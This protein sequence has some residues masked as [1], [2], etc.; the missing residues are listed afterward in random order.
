MGASE[1]STGA[2]FGMADARI[3]NCVRAPAIQRDAWHACFAMQV[4]WG[5]F[6]ARYNSGRGAIPLMYIPLVGLFFCSFT[7]VTSSGR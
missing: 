4:A 1:G 3:G 2:A 7:S 6:Q 5:V